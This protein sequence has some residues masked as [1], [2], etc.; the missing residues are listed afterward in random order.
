M[1][2]V[3]KL[4]SVQLVISKQNIHHYKFQNNK[5]KIKYMSKHIN[6]GIVLT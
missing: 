5:P 1:K 2:T 3:I 4:L 6:E